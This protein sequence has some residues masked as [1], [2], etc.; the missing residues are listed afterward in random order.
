MTYTSPNSPTVLGEID[1]N[2]KT[3]TISNKECV[4]V[5]VNIRVARLLEQIQDDHNDNIKIIMI[6]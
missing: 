5:R 2:A 4:G 6:Y 1:R 3:Y